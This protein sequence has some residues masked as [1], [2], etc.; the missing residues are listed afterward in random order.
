[1]VTAPLYLL[2]M[3]IPVYFLIKFRKKRRDKSA[4]ASIILYFLSFTFLVLAL[5]GFGIIREKSRDYTIFV[6]DV[7][8]SVSAKAREEAAEII[9]SRLS[10]LEPEDFAGIVLFGN[11]GMI[12]RNLQNN[13]R[14]VTWESRVSGRATNIEE[15]IYKAIGMFPEE[16]KRSILLFSDGLENLG[17]GRNAAVRAASAGIRIYTVPLYSEKPESEVYI[18][19]FIV[20]GKI[21]VNQIHDYTLIVGSTV[22]TAA[23]VTFFRDGT[24]MGEER[25]QIYNGLNTFTYSSRLEEAGIHEYRALIEPDTDT[26]MENNSMTVPVTVSG[27]PKIMIVSE[28]DSPYLAEA[29]AVQNI[30]SDIVKPRMIPGTAGRLLE[31]ESIIFDNIP[32]G[33]VSISTMELI[34]DYV[35]NKGGGFIMVGGNKSFGAGGYYDTPLEEILPVDMDVTSSLQIPSLTMIMV[36]DRSGSMKSAVERGVIKL[37]VAKEAVM[38]AVE[39]LNPFYRVGI[40]AFDTD[41]YFAVPMIEAKEVDAIRNQLMLVEPKG[42]TSL[43][44]AM[45]AAYKELLSSDSAVRHMIILSDGLSEDG[46]FESLT[47]EIGDQGIT[48]STVSVGMDSDRDLMENIALWGG[49]RSY[50]SSDI[51]DVPRIFASESFIVSR[52]HIVEET[53]LP[54]ESIRHEIIEGMDEPFPALDGFVLTYPKSGA[55]HILTSNENHPLLSAWNYGL[56]KTASWSSDFSG[57]WGSRLVS[58]DKFPRFAAQLIRW[59]ER[60]VTEQN[61]T[62]SFSGTGNHRI[63][64]INAEDKESNYIN[65]LN[66]Q[67]II[68]S[69]DGSEQILDVFQR[70]PGLYRASFDLPAEGTSLITVYDKENR[71]EPEVTGISIPYSSEFRPMNEDF[72]L[73]VELAEFT[74]GTLINTGNPDFSIIDSED[75]SGT[76]DMKEPLVM[77]ALILFLANIVIRLLSG[78]KTIKKEIS[79]AEDLIDLRLKIDKGKQETLY[80]RRKDRFW[81][82]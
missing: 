49:G 72:S 37:D 15:A 40:I 73:L 24:Y 69:P 74:G 48:V 4:R 58:W 82:G 65:K 30:D 17:N 10:E 14:H 42:G 66:L 6:I 54:G 47:K 7:S 53:F 55:M 60:P 5:A 45:E 51:R 26:Y 8:D 3:L 27:E 25:I 33:S 81:F 1:M 50:Y 22:R 52:A 43:Y 41:F 18:Q 46:E 62:F 2:L 31:Y 32:S 35:K 61:L 44:P 29:L 11:E 71:I 57:R 20:P 64:V 77:A 21:S 16:G 63:L 12:E 34:K 70:G 19:D 67:A 79:E 38:E 28:S 23:R 78:R 59:V 56:G 39:I 76:K 80:R 68:T 13:L 9:N 75:K 36:I